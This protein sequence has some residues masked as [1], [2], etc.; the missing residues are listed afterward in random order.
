M[1][2]ESEPHTLE[3]QKLSIGLFLGALQSIKF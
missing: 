1:N 2:S 3:K